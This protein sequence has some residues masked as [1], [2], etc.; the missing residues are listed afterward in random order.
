MLDRLPD[1]VNGD[2]ALVRRGR[3]ID[4][5]FLLEVGPDA[6]LIGVQSGRITDFRTGPFVMPRWVFA[7]RA[8]AP[9]W[10]L[11][12]QPVPPPGS[13][14]LFALIKR[15]VLTAEG[16]LHVFMANLLYFKEALAK[17]RGLIAAPSP[18]VRP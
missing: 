9:A 8:P 2:A 18:D 11:F 12:W 13:H 14:D 4:V 7:L 10:H 5:T 1:L 16:D 17:P 15:R 3:Y 6:R